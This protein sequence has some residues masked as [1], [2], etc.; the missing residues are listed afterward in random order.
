[1]SAKTIYRHDYQPYPFSVEYIELDFDLHEKKTTV[2][3]T[4]RFRRLDIGPLFLYGDELTLIHVML[5]GKK[6]SNNSYKIVDQNLIIE[7]VP[8]T[9]ELKIKTELSPSTNTKLSGLYLS[10]GI[11][12]TQCEAEGFRRITYFPDRPDVLTKYRTKITAEKK[13]YPVLLSNGNLVKQGENAHGK[14]WAIWE[15]PFKKPSYLFALVAGN[16]DVIRDHYI[17]KSGRSVELRIYAEKGGASKCSHAMRSLKHAMQWDEDNYDRE[18]DLD[19]YMIVSVSDFNMGAM[20]N[21]GLNI[22]NAKY[23]LVSPKTATD[24]DYQGVEGVI[25]HEYFHNWT[26]NRVTCRDWF[27]LSLKEGLTVFRDQCFSQD[28]FARDVKRIEDVKIIRNVQFPEDDGPMAHPVRPESYEEINNFYT[29]TIYNKGA[30][31]I[32]MQQTILGIDG[33]RRG[34]DLYFERHDGQAVTIDDF[35]AAME[36]AND[37]NLTQFKQWYSQAGTPEVFVTRHEKNGKLSLHITQKNSFWTESSLIKPFHIPITIAAFNKNGAQFELPKDLI[38]LKHMEQFFD[39][40]IPAT[41]TISLLRNFS[42]PIKMHFDQTEEELLTIMQFETNGV[43]KWDAVQKL[44]LNHLMR[45]VNKHSKTS[46]YSKSISPKLAAAYSALF[47]NKN[48]DKALCAELLT[49]P[50]FEDVA[51]M[52]KIVDVDLIE[53]ARKNMQI[54][55]ARAIQEPALKFIQDSWKNETHLMTPKDFAARKLR[56]V[57]L[58]LLCKAD[59]MEAW[60]LCEAQFYETKT[61]SDEAA[62]L[63]ILAASKHSDK[64]EAAKDG[65]ITK[66]SNHD[67]V[68]DKWF[69]AIASADLTETLMR[70]EHLLSHPK[71]KF[72]QPNK[73]RALIGSFCFANHRQFHQKNGEGYAFLADMVLKLDR[74]NPQLAARLVTPFTKFSRYDETRKTLMR[75]WLLRLSK[76]KLSKD[77]S[78]IVTKTLAVV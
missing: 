69:A 39:F 45:E 73:V 31:V 52:C 74:G 71:F 57:C 27:Q 8:D 54:A 49:P 11:F 19:I 77:V 13:L 20:E 55:I 44:A 15:D 40:D 30:E 1:M 28:R 18:Y 58:S 12:C 70:I 4:M 10:N 29:T 14:H 22:F 5:D 65:F 42:A 21:K 37:I 33:F 78:E 46:Q 36:D 63:F 75:K 51:S 26:G 76:E 35:V 47:D 9:F 7:N 6:L 17:T 48:S 72:N 64:R 50:A 34:M 60:D 2:L 56:H 16:L 25:A 23:I 68:L 66:W 41:A 3:T 24:Q 32:R 62:A 59:L 53:D 61:M 38:E 67:L 43:A